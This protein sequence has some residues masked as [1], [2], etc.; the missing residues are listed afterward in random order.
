METITLGVFEKNASAYYCYKSVG[1]R[2]TGQ[3]EEYVIAGDAWKCVEMELRKS[4][5][6]RLYFGLLLIMK[7]IL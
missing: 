5:V 4:W 6:C 1:F 2:E 7:E 3:I